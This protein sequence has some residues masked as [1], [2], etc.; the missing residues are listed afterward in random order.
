MR[1]SD[2]SSDVCSSD[3]HQGV[4][5]EALHHQLIERGGNR[6]R[7][8]MAGAVASPPV[9]AHDV[10]DRDHLAVLAQQRPLIE[11]A[12]ESGGHTA[13]G[14]PR[15]KIGSAACMERVCKTVYLSVVGHLLNNK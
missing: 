2:W 11:L 8:G 15:D 7:L 13:V 14:P 1:I 10:L 9:P 5:V 3:L 6:R 12:D 4:F